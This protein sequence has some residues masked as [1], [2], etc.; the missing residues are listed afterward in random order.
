[1]GRLFLPHFAGTMFS[2]IHIYLDIPYPVFYVLVVL[3]LYLSKPIARFFNRFAL[4][5]QLTLSRDNGDAIQLPLVQSS[6]ASAPPRWFTL[7]G[8]VLNGIGLALNVLCQPS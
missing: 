5:C 4:A 2:L 1:M 8:L 6:R 7:A 3:I